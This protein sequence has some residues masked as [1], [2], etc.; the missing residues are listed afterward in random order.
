MTGILRLLAT[1]LLLAS[2]SYAGADTI[3]TTVW[4]GEYELRGWESNV[5]PLIISCEEF[6]SRGITDGD[7][8]RLS[9]KADETGGY[10]KVIYRSADMAWLEWPAFRALPGIDTRYGTLRVDS[11][12]SVDIPVGSDALK[13]IEESSAIIVH[14]VDVTVTGIEILHKSAIPEIHAD[15]GNRPAEYYNLRGIR[16][17]N[18]ETGVYIRRLGDSVGKV[19][20]K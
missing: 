18:P 13:V 19:L 6:T 1:V 3:V 4:E 8:I 12:G 20:V 14:G 10:F 9:Y 16:V 5:V 15:A 17:E 2:A 11:P 7:I